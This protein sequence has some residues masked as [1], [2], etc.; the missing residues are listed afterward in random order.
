MI[1]ST[2]GFPKDT[3]PDF[4]KVSAVYMDVKEVFTHRKA[5]SL[6]PHRPYD[7][8]TDLHPGTTPPRGQLFSLSPPE[9]EA[10]SSY[11]T[12]AL[13]LGLIQPCFSPVGAGVF[14][15]RKKNGGLQ[16]CID[17]RGLNNI[18]VKNRYSLRF[19]GFANFYRKFIR[20]YGSVAAPL[21]QFTSCK[22]RFEWSPKAEQ[23]AV[24]LLKTSFTTAP[25]RSLVLF[26]LHQP[27]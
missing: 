19:L 23:S 11:M 22:K 2:E 1:P 14:F 26:C 18:T 20:G 17:Y 3:F 25:K 7:C 5:T 21:H 24:Q 13:K 9:Q 6:P 15:V 27:A 4:S 8:T 10:M 12:E 16:P